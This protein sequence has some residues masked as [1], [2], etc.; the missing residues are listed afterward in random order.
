VGQ[1]SKRGNSLR[2]MAGAVRW[3]RRGARLNHARAVGAATAEQ[4]E[5]LREAQ[6]EAP[7]FADDVEP[8]FF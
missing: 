4:H 8:N 7:H 3:G 1:L 2:V 5:L 6:Q